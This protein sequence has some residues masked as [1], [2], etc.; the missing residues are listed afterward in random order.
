MSLKHKEN[1]TMT[2]EDHKSIVRRFINAFKTNDQDTLTEV[3]ALDFM[4]HVPGL[5]G[6]V[7]RETLFQRIGLLSAAF[8]DLSVTIEDQVAE[9]D[10]VA[11]RFTWRGTHTGDFQGFSPTGMQVEIS[12]VSIERFKSGKIV[13]RWFNQDDLGL[14]MQLGLFP[15]P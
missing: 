10:K 11:T 15:S 2:N 1:T 14:M 8:S 13:E 5:A 12:A 7:D 3:V 9:E 4:A 6:P